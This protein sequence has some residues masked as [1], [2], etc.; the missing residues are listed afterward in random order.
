MVDI[1]A[2]DAP[3]TV[4]IEAT[5]VLTAHSIGGAV[6]VGGNIVQEYTGTFSI[7]NGATNYLSGTFPDTV[8]GGGSSLA[9]TASTGVSGE[10]VMYTSNVLP[11][12]LVNGTDLGVSF[13]LTSVSPGASTVVSGSTRT[14]AAFS[15]DISGDFSASAVPEP[16]TWAMMVLGFIGLGYAA[17]H[18]SAKGR[19]VAI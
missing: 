13:S 10:T 14:L 11:A 19:A 12:N 7:T 6:T 18:R 5:L 15:S 9:L 1:T 8:F 4:P 2:I 3:L 16:A 17:F